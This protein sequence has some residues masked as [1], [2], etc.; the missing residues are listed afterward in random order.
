M[1]TYRICRL[2]MNESEASKLQTLYP[3]AIQRLALSLACLLAGD[4]LTCIFAGVNGKGIDT[5]LAALLYTVV[6]SATIWMCGVWI[7]I[8][9]IP[10]A[11]QLRWW[12]V[13]LAGVH[14]CVV[15]FLIWEYRNRAAVLFPPRT[16]ADFWQVGLLHAFCAALYVLCLRRMAR[17]FDYGMS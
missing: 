1:A 15:G 4:L 13:P 17:P 11:A 14:T 10:I 6:F 7:A 12:I 9:A 5:G 2:P 3:R 16:L 8:L